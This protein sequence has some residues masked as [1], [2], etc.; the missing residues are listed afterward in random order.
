[1]S[2][3]IKK[4]T[5]RGQQMIKNASYNQGSELWHVYDNYSQEK[6][7]SFID[8]KN[9]CENDNGYDFRIIS[10]NTFAYS[11]AWNYIDEEGAEVLRIE[12]ANNSYIIK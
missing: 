9:W 5:K 10:H 12:T 1:M 6:A 7:R 11:V 4:T 2:T 8:C 3:I